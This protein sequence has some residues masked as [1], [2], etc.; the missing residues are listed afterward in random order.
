MLTVFNIQTSQKSMILYTSCFLGSFTSSA[1]WKHCTKF[2]CL[3][4]S[5]AFKYI[6]RDE[7]T[8]VNTIAESMKQRRALLLL[9]SH[10]INKKAFHSVQKIIIEIDIGKFRLPFLCSQ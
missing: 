4:S 2:L 3:P 6:F 1:D 8:A 7:D 10:L 5:V 9:F